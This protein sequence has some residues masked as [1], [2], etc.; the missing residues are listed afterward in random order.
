MHVLRCNALERI[1]SHEQFVEEEA[2]TVEIKRFVVAFFFYHFRSNVL[3]TTA[4][5]VHLLTWD[6][7]A[8]VSEITYFDS[9]FL[10]DQYVLR[11]EVSIN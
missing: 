11:F 10:I 1:A 3:V 7:S 8:S 5:T 2:Q 9:F 4:Q 6:D